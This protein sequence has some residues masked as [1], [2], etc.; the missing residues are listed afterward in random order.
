[1]Y[2]V[3][4]IKSPSMIRQGDIIVMGDDEIAHITKTEKIPGGAILHLDVG[5][6]DDVIELSDD[7]L[8]VRL[9]SKPLR[10]T[11]NTT[12]RLVFPSNYGNVGER[13]NLSWNGTDRWI[14]VNEFKF[15]K[16]RHIVVECLKGEMK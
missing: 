4:S 9:T 3:Q 8:V 1:M 11:G 15:N 6:S 5:D 2:H 13:A 7:D 10:D 14:I 16:L 12:N